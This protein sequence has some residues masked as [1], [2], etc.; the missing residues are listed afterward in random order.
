MTLD[1]YLTRNKMTATEMAQTLGRAIS[2]ITRIRKG[3]IKPDFDTIQE[4]VDVTEGLVTPND[5][6]VMPAKKTRK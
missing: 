1:Q 2:T 5:F 3:E 6:F 4:L